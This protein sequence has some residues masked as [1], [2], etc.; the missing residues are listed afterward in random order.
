M[1]VVYGRYEANAHKM[2]PVY[3]FTKG[4]RRKL[5]AVLSQS[6]RVRSWCLYD[7]EFA[8]SGELVSQ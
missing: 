4:L 3:L 6:R 7:G 8:V 5:R 1:T 2:C